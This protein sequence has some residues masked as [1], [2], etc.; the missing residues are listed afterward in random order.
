M[1]NEINNESDIA[2]LIGEYTGTLMGMVDTIELAPDV[3]QRMQDKILE[4][5]QTKI[6]LTN[7]ASIKFVTPDRSFAYKTA[8]F[9]IEHLI[10]TTPTSD[11]RNRLTEINLLMLS[12]LPVELIRV[13]IIPKA[14]SSIRNG[15]CV[16]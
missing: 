5:R 3:K 11:T 1:K 12:L 7:P 13:S 4:L 9:C 16:L 10:N 15:S 14:T 8:L 6:V 2:R